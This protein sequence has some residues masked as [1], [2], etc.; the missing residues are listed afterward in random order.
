M[1]KIYRASIM[2]LAVLL[3][4]VLLTGVFTG[5]ASAKSEFL[6][7]NLLGQAWRHDL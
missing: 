5:Q 3:M 7:N 1:T 2:A 6:Q 4:L